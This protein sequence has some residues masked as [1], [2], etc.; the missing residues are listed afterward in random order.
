MLLFPESQKNKI[1][2]FPIVFGVLGA[3]LGLFLRY[4]FTGVAAPFE[5]KHITHAHSHVMLLGFVFNAL[6]GLLWI[7]FT[8]TIDKISFA[9]YIALQVCVSF[10]LVGFL[11]QGYAPFTIVFSTLHL[12]LSYVLLLRLW[13]R[14]KGKQLL[15][16][17][18]KIGIV[19]HFIA[20][21]G[22]YALGPLKVLG[23]Q[24]SPWYQ[25]AIFFYL[26]FQY[27]GSFFIWLIA[28]YLK[29]IKLTFS[30]KQISILLIACVLLYAHSL[31]YSFN[32]W[33]VTLS[34]GIGSVL[35]LGVFLRIHI[36][37]FQQKLAYQLLYTVVLLIL[38][39][40]CFGSIPYISE[41]V[42]SNRFV[43]IAW[44]HLL[45]LGLYLPFIW[46]ELPIKIKAF[47]WILFA[48]FVVF[49]ELL[50]LFPGEFSVVFSS[51]VLWLLFLAYLGVVLCICIVHLTYI[52]E[53]IKR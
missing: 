25:Q 8:D 38:L 21:F 4:V 23:M 31:D 34:G 27:F 52:F 53:R 1:W 2:I 47:T 18:V 15:V 26:H 40:N 41:M 30:K 9:I 48:I 39:G 20:S 44:L 22:P 5:I 43:L 42:A 19:L 10:L 32:H 50:L 37:A 35:L 13:K 17:C 3:L 49:T 28:V 46:I 45:F 51:S 24:D 7:H 36:A 33:L 16:L 12:W 6:V 29:Q 11:I 14:L